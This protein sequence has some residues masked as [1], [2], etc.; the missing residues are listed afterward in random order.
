MVWLQ[1][2]RTMATVD[3]TECC[4]P[5]NTL[6]PLKIIKLTGMGI[7]KA[8]YAV[9]YKGCWVKTLMSLGQCGKN[10]HLHRFKPFNI[11]FLK[12]TH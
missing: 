11:Y 8:I 12:K 2:S 6:N 7:C 10:N 3:A 5:H 9:R 1:G 4:K